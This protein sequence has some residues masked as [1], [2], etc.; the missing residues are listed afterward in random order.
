VGVLSF[1]SAYLYGKTVYMAKSIPVKPKR[2]RPPSGGRD[3]FVGIRLP[4]SLIDQIALWSD[5]QD[6]ASRSEAIRRLVE[7][8]LKAK[9]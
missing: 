2:G 4:A 8:G 6:L 3:P 7:L 5:E 9:K 1:P